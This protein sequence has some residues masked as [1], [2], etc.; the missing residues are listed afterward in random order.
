MRLLLYDIKAIIYTIVL[1]LSGTMSGWVRI[2]S[3]STITFGYGTYD[4]ANTDK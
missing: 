3:Q 4:V 2:R 1:A